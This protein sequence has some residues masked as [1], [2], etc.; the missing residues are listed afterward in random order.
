MEQDILR[1]RF[2]L[3]GEG[4]MTLREVG[5]LHNLSRERIRQL[6]ERALGALR[7]KFRQ[8]GLV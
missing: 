4:P 7:R 1:R 5:L 2:G 8:T 6:Q 3:D